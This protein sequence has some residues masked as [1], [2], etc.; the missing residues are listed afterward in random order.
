MRFAGQIFFASF[1]V[2]LLLLS[3]LAKLS[4]GP[5]VQ[6]YSNKEVI[7]GDGEGRGHKKAKKL[8]SPSIDGPSGAVHKFHK[9]FPAYLILKR[10]YKC[11]DRFPPLLL[12]LVPPLRDVHRSTKRLTTIVLTFFSVFGDTIVRSPH[13][14]FFFHYLNVKRYFKNKSI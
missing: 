7:L 13:I 5:L 1:Q 8:R 14:L 12:T 2:N 3:R 9:V 11:E 6:L 10:G 4:S